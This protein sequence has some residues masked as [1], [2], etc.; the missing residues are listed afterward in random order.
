MSLN[1]VKG[2]IIAAIV[3][4]G[5]ILIA[6]F[7]GGLYPKPSSSQSQSSNSLP[8]EVDPNTPHLVSTNPKGLKEGVLITPS[9]II[10]ISFSHPIENRGEVKYQVT[11]EV[12]YNIELTDDRKTVLLNPVRPYGTGRGFSFIIK[13]DTKFDG[14]KRLTSD[15]VFNFNTIPHRGI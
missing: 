4:L 2:K 10:E 11:P 5:L 9:Q 13:Q 6:I 3:A 8:Q 1:T 7:M 15:E 14:G 12:E